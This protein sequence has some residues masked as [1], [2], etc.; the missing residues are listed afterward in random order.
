MANHDNHDENYTSNSG[1]MHESSD[2]NVRAIYM[3][4][5][6]LVVLGV[7]CALATYGG[8]RALEAYE[9][10]QDKARMAANPMVPEARMKMS[11]EA[12]AHEFPS[13]QLQRDD[14]TEMNQEIAEE[15]AK[16][17]HY[18]WVDQGQG[19]VRI[20][21]DQ[22]MQLVLQRGL[23]ARSAGENAAAAPVAGKVAAKPAATKPAAPG[24]PA[25][26]HVR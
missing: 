4:G 18:Q 12:T 21:I 10:H 3:F 13:P 9:D 24:K 15:N 5:V 2:A 17:T 1:V 25:S 22:A 20:P 19:V 23:P 26:Q 8:L 6:W 7:L 11:T 16:L 14:T